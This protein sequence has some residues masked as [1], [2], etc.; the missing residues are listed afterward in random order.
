MANK[1]L[2]F[3][4]LFIAICALF[5]PD[6]EH[7][8]FHTCPLAFSRWKSLLPSSSLSSSSQLSEIPLR[9]FTLE[10]L[11]EYDGTQ[12]EMP[13]YLAVGGKVLDVTQ[14]KKFYKKG[15]TYHQFAG[16]VNIIILLLY[17]NLHAHGINLGMYKSISTWFIRLEG[18]Y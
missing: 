17:V 14:G 16:T 8:F 15:A 7:L 3:L 1:A 4:S 12:E 18:K 2:L 5:W 13:I 10:E 9:V 11:K 6:L